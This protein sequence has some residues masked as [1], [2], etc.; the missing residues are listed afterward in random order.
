MGKKA[1]I[2]NLEEGREQHFCAT[3]TFSQVLRDYENNNS[4]GLLIAGDANAHAEEWDAL[5]KED[6]IGSD[7]VDFL[8]DN[9]FIVANCQRWTSYVSRWLLP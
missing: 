3:E 1:K 7:T 9:T 8:D 4:H 2:P 5:S 6:S